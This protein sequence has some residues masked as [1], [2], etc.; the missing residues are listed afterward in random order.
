M[1]VHSRYGW[2]LGVA[3]FALIV[4]G[5]L[6]PGSAMA[7]TSI[8]G[9]VTDASTGA[10][11]SGIE[12]DAWYWDS[13]SAA[14]KIWDWTFTATDGTYSFGDLQP[15]TYRVGFSDASGGYVD[16]FYNGQPSIDVA[17]NLIVDSGTIPLNGIDGA[18]VPVSLKGTILSSSSHAGIAGVVV[19]LYRQ[20]GALWI[21][22]VAC[23]TDQFGRYHFDSL[24]D[25]VW[26][27]GAA[28]AAGRFGQRF[29]TDATSV[30]TADDVTTSIG[31]SQQG[32]DITLPDE[33]VAPTVITDIAASYI[34][35]ARI[36]LLG[37]DP[38]PASGVVSVTYQVDSGPAVTVP[39]ATASLSVSGVGSHT[40]TFYATDA[41]GNVGTPQSKTFSI[42]SSPVS[43]TRVAGVD[44]FETA[45]A[46]ARY[47]RTSWTGVT[48]VIL[49]SGEDRA[50]ADPLS[51]AGLS[52]AYNGAPLLLTRSASVPDSV[53]QLIAEIVS[54]NRS[55]TIVGVGGTASLP[56]ARI[57]EIRKGV[58]ARLGM[59][60]SAATTAVGFDRIIA[61]GDRYQLAAAVAGRMKAVRPSG[62]GAYALVANGADPAKFFDALS[63][64]AVSASSGCPVLLVKMDAVPAATAAAFTSLGIGGSKV[65]VAGGGA[66]VAPKVL[67]MMGVSE[68]QRMA[69]PDRYATSTAVADRALSLGLLSGTSAGV[70]AKITDALSGGAYAGSHGGPILVT[71][72]ASLSPVTSMWLS[73]HKATIKTCQMFGGEVSL[74]PLTAFQIGAALK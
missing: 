32:V 44:R 1:R 9:T 63:L 68:S 6:V 31:L 38:A 29:Y 12:V 48:H 28:D 60:L 11:L 47:G 64:S 56:D 39:G 74:S 43:I 33:A 65:L 46:V 10:L 16:Q 35:V 7:A 67:A 62:F 18:L 24:G 15:N 8:A 55:V 66:S 19:S 73:A 21:A 57:L 27:V 54:A 3:L 2:L 51:A 23:V 5:A 52:W 72:G 69:G 58:A 45:I 26:R 37:S 53:E 22:D 42:A 36:N 17:S 70:A 13:A 41:A 40:I 50:L 30:E 4:A 20:S 14:W 25:G 34:D 61:G 71:S 49:A 59:S